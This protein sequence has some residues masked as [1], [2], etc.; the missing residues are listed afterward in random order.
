[1]SRILRGSA[2]RETSE[3]V[4]PLFARSSAS[5]GRTW[6]WVCAVAL[7]VV[8]VVSARPADAAIVEQQI[9]LH[10]GWNLI[11]LRVQPTDSAPAAVLASLLAGQSP[12]FQALWTYDPSSSPEWSAYLGSS[13]VQPPQAGVITSIESGR[14]YWIR[15]SRQTT[16]TVNGNDTSLPN[17]LALLASGWNMVGITSPTAQRYDRVFASLLDEGAD[18]GLRE[19]WSF[20]PANGFKGI[21][22][23]TGS[24]TPTLEE[25]TDLVPG[26]AYW[27]RVSEGVNVTPELAT[28]IPG[29]IDVAPLLSGVQ[30][31]VRLSWGAKSAGDVNIGSDVYGDVTDTYYDRPETQRYLSFPETVEASAL[32]ISNLGGGILNWLVT[33]EDEGGGPPPDWLRIRVLD[34]IERTEDILTSLSG[35]TTSIGDSVGLVVDR[36]GLAPGVYKAQLRVLSNGDASAEPQRI[37]KVVMRVAGLEGDYEIRARIDTIDGNPADTANPRLFLS[38]YED[39]GGLHAIIDEDRTLLVSRDVRMNGR[40]YQDATNR[41]LLSGSF[42]LSST[43]PANPYGVALRRD[44]TLLGRR[45]EAGDEPDDPEEVLGPLD[46]TGEYRETVRGVLERPVYLAGTFVARR[47]GAVATARDVG[48]DP[49]PDTLNGNDVFDD[50]P[51]EKTIEVT[52][53][54]RLDEVD[55]DVHVDHLRPSDLSIA[56]I[57]PDGTEVLLRDAGSTEPAGYRSYDAETEPVDPLS[58][59]TGKLSKGTWRL[60]IVDHEPGESATFRSWSLDLKGTRVSDITGRVELSGGA[61]AVGAR[62]T[63]EGCGQILYATTNGSGEYAFADLIDCAYFV[64]AQPVDLLSYQSAGVAV[65]VGGETDPTVAPTIMFGDVDPPVV[66]DDVLNPLWRCLQQ[67]RCQIVL[68]AEAAGSG[69]APNCSRMAALTNLGTSGTLYLSGAHGSLVEQSP[70]Q[71]G[72]DSATFDLD[73]ESPAPGSFPQLE[74]LDFF[75]ASENAGT[76]TNECGAYDTAGFCTGAGGGG[77]PDPAVG[78]NTQRI[79]VSIGMPVVGTSVAGADHLTIGA[80]FGD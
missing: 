7:V 2:G 30:P 26:R 74:D 3:M 56:L 35:A 14:G 71:Y 29:D 51:I 31:G 40:V 49:G 18:E 24:T 8:S 19:I 25:F 34:P 22:I 59:L 6:R 80:Q 9:A 61:A 39:N 69:C 72:M 5:A 78:E 62:V 48:L 37:M 64:S 65:D 20:E 79:V 68:P 42:A 4:R 12:A 32:S 53:K 77:G 54:L 28:A 73:R 45:A 63:L 66:Q 43:D 76:K 55:T 1:M 33:V 17:S 60:R 27:V 23:P 75:K 44:I 21:V 10:E 15:V 46:L 38:V 58:L 50:A 16:L 36:T 67:S 13:P 41:I 70:L 52:R 57:S 11:S 47:V